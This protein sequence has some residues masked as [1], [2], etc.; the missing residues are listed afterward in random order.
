M[1]R[2]LFYEWLRVLEELQPRAF[3]A[4]NVSGMTK[5]V[6]KGYYLD[7]LRKMAALGYQ[8]DARLLDAQYLGVPQRRLRV[9]FLGLRNDLG[10][11]PTFPTPQPWT[12]SVREALPWLDAARLDT[13]GQFWSGDFIDTPS[14]TLRQVASSAHQY[15]VRDAIQSG[16]VPSRW[17]SADEPSPAI[18]ASRRTAMQSGGVPSRWHSA[19]EPA[20]TIHS[21]P[22]HFQ[23][24]QVEQI[25]GN[26]KYEPTWGDL[27]QP[28]ATLMSGG[29]GNTS[30]EI[31]LGTQRRK[32]TIRELKRLCAFP[33]DFQMTGSYAQQ[34]ARFGNS[35]PPLMAAAIAATL[36][37]TLRQVDGR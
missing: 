2:I 31:R 37:D 35:V 10:L 5:G 3:V 11:A 26:D 18:I 9:I 34:W 6:S 1:S 29:S 28:H 25:I 22:K 15:R 12:Y 14:P 17:H 4:E 13:H 36:R 33:E 16:G 7:V 21:D 30:G 32:F 23:R 24:V 19:D 8:A 20:P 27:D